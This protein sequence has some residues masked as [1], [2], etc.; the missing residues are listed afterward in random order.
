MLWCMSLTN[1]ERVKVRKALG[2]VQTKLAVTFSLGIVTNVAYQQL[3]ERAMDQLLPEA[4]DY[5][6]Q[7]LA[8]FDEIETYIAEDTDTVIASSI[9]NI[10]LNPD[11]MKEL[12]KRY[13]YWRGVLSNALGVPAA[14]D[15]A[16]EEMS[17]LNVSVIHG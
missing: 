3:A 7:L 4:E 14:P 6:R 10:T 11:A 15:D 5:I 9:G 2:Y 17:S 8:R 1:E 16:R 13:K 12:W